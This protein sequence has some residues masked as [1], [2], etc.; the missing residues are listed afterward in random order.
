MQSKSPQE[1]TQARLKELLHYDPETGVFTWI[2]RA[3]RCAAGT[4]ADTPDK[5]GYIRIQ[6]DGVR[7]FAHRLAFLYMTGA[8]PA[9]EVDHIDGDPQN[10]AFANLR[11]VKHADNQHNMGGA[12][13]NNKTNL[14]GVIFNPRVNK[15][16]G[17]IMVARRSIH[18]GSFAT[19]EL[20]HAAYLKA[21]NELHPTHQRLRVAA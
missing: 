20:A 17:K 5:H 7:F 10:N 12:Q 19:P 18:L 16:V 9:D 2:K 21:K 4:P 13:R 8:L 14:L 11:V 15:W 6:V 1:L 3:G